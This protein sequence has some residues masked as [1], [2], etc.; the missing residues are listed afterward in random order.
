MPHR[1]EHVG[2]GNDRLAQRAGLGDQ[3]LLERGHALQ[4]NLNTQVAAGHHDRV[5]GRGDRRDAANR[6]GA[7]DLGEDGHL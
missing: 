7:L 4:R 2:R 6:L 1:V 5:E 3:G